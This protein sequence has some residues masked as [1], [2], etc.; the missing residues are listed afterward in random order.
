MFLLYVAIILIVVSIYLIPLPILI[1]ICIVLHLFYL[2]NK[3]TPGKEIDT[4]LKK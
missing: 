1:F 2:I 4:K 3:D